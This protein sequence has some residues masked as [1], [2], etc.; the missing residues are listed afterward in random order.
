MLRYLWFCD[1]LKQEPFSF[2]RDAAGHNMPPEPSSSGLVVNRGGTRVFVSHNGESSVFFGVVFKIRVVES[3][4]KHFPLLVLS[5]LCV[6][7]QPKAQKG[8]AAEKVVHPYS[9]K[10]AYLAREEIR[11]KRKERLE[12]KKGSECG[13]VYWEVRRVSS[14]LGPRR[15]A[16]TK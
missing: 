6:L 10:A 12:N 9:R 3:A 15:S 8:K 16:I 4:T 13:A 2:L 1:G 7:F 5:S 11:L 14:P